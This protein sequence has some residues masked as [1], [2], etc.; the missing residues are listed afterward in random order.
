MGAPK[1]N[2]NA[3]THYLTIG[4]LPPGCAYITRTLTA[5]RRAIKDAVI[6]RHGKLGFFDDA[7]IQ[8]AIRW[9]RQALLTQRFLREEK[10]LS[11]ERKIFF[12]REIARA[13]AERDKCLRELG[14]DRR[15]ATR[16]KAG[17]IVYVPPEAS[18]EGAT[19]EPGS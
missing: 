4:T 9:E 10:N 3:A 12:S 8:S 13:S 7:I 5:L 6:K 17:D 19:D 1:G 15:A 11:T 2:T 16:T 14:L 18:Q